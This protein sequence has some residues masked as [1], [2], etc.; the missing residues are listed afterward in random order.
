MQRHVHAFG[1]VIGHQRRDADAEVDVVTVA[2]FLRC[3]L[4]HQ[5]ADWVLFFRSRA[6]L[7]GAK[8]DAFLVLAAL[9]DA[10]DEDARRVDLVRIQLADFDELLDLGDADRATS[11]DHRVEVP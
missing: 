8:L 10:V 6:A 7:H 3:A 11:G 4:G 9:D 2:Q 1:N 5:L